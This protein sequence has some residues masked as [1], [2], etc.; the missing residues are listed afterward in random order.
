[1]SDRDKEATPLSDGQAGTPHR[2][3]EDAQ[4]GSMV[5]DEQDMKRLGNDMER[6]QTNA[7]LEEEGL[8]PDPI[9]E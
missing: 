1:M 9:Q 6:V 4:N 8:V 5:Q 2:D 3:V 7:E